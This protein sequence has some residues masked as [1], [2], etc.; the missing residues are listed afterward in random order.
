MH[1]WDT[2]SWW[3]ACPMMIQKTDTSPSCGSPCSGPP[4]LA[5]RWSQRVGHYL[6]T[7]TMSL[8]WK[9]MPFLLTSPW[10]ELGHLATQ[11]R[12][13]TA[14]TSPQRRG[15]LCDCPWS[16]PSFKCF[17]TLVLL[18]FTCWMCSWL[19]W[20]K[21]LELSLLFPLFWCSSTAGLLASW[22]LLC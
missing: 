8:T 2:P 21:A 15:N 13:G 9:H 19:L 22:F 18:F 6:W 17:Q 20:P 16:L 7:T 14:V 4:P 1:L 10:L 11:G 12:L 3:V 5:V